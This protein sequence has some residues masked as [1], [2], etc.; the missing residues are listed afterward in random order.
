MTL[1]FT[2]G[3]IADT[4]NIDGKEIIDSTVEEVRDVIIKLVSREKDLGTLQYCFMNLMESQGEYSC[5]NHP[6]SSCG[7]YISTYTLE[8]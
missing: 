3:C 6:C 7:D 8:I 1:E 5:S 4:T 2:T